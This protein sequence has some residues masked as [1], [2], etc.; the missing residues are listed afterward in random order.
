MPELHLANRDVTFVA[1]F[2]APLAKLESFKRRMGWGFKWASAGENGFNYDYNVSFKPELIAKA[3]SVYNYQIVTR[4]VRPEH[5]G[6][7]E[8]AG[9]S[10]FHKS[11]HGELFHTYSC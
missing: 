4:A 10:A 3:E 9:M 5:A 7:S 11:P 1:I 6:L 8:H 2:H